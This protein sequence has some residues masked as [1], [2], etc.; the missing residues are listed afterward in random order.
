MICFPRRI[1][2]ETA[3]ERNDDI[4]PSLIYSA[5]VVYSLVGMASSD[6][7]GGGGA[8]QKS[9]EHEEAPSRPQREHRGGAPARD[10]DARNSN[11][12]SPSTNRASSGS[13]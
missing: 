8:R 3:Q 2:V 9:P 5:G 4:I 1:L 11:E 13:R 7:S 6:A 12:G 10:A